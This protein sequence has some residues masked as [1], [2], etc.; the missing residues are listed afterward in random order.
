MISPKVAKQLGVYET[1]EGKVATNAGGIGGSVPAVRTFIDRVKVGGAKDSFIP[2][3]VVPSTSPAWEGLIGMDFM[4]KYSFKIDSVKRV[5]VFEEIA[6][7]PNSPCG[8]N[9]QWWKGLFKEFHSLGAAWKSHAS[10][11]ARSQQE[12]Q[13]AVRQTKEADK[14]L[15]KLDRYASEHSVP[16]TWR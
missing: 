2:A 10:Q 4:S 12:Y 9:E 6:S 11:R 5:V 7:D 8:H 16:Q 14:L 15:N 13:F 3:Y 1:D